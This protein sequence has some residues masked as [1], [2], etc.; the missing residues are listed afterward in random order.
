MASE[1][2]A[3]ASENGVMAPEN[4]VTRTPSKSRKKRGGGEMF[5]GEVDDV[6]EG[7]DGGEC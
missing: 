1:N 3:M 2:G 7:L 4:D 6:E 5:L